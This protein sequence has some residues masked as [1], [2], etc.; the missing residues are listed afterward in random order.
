M[1]TPRSTQRLRWLLTHVAS[2]PSPTSENRNINGDD[3][4]G[5]LKTTAITWDGWD[6]QQHKVLPQQY[7]G[8][9]AAEVKAGDILV[10]KA[11]PRN[12][13]GVSVYVD[14][15]PSRLVASGKMLLLR[16]DRMVTDP[17]FLSWIL[18]TPSSQSYL[19]ARK[20]GMAE[21]QMN[22][23]NN[24]LLGMSLDI[25]TL[26]E[27]RRIAD[28]LES[29]TLQIGRLL[30]ARKKQQQL[31]R[32]RQSLLLTGATSGAVRIE[33]NKSDGIIDGRRPQGEERSRIARGVLAAEAPADWEIVPLRRIMQKLSRKVAPTDS[34]IT[35]Y[36][37]GTVT[38]RSQRREEGY[39]FSDLEQGY[40]G[41]DPG[42][43]VFHALDGF[44][45]AV[46]VSDA[47]GKSS[48]VYHVC[49]MRADD[50]P[51]FMAYALRAMGLT[52]YLALQAG[53][54]RQRSVDFRP[55]ESL[56]RITMPRPPVKTQRAI[57]AHLTSARIWTDEVLNAIDRQTRLLAERR[58]ALITAAV[59]GQFD[60]S[61]ASGR[62]VSEGLQV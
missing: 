24:D 38:L 4:W 60:V 31:V 61:T 55:W 16:P 20:T 6:W 19:D 3:E 26:D 15:S 27:Q 32:E 22:F 14:H 33:R 10:T 34:V 40:Q 18:G 36:R 54:V 8:I 42:D 62:N 9:K 11:G 47:R 7:W 37:D 50:D 52:G 2:G 39:T 53:N 58:Q 56:A 1:A 21:S 59:T 12:R 45:G 43:L 48:P 46:G 5:V 49:S 57:S 28:Y 41:V 13:V 29:A 30:A 35:A 17:R 44:A 23:T 51:Q 25:P